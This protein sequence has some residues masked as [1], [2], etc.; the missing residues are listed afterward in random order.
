MIEILN[1]QRTVSVDCAALHAFAEQALVRCQ[2]LPARHLDQLKQ[3]SVVLVSDREISRLHRQFLGC[4]RATDVITFDHGE[5]VISAQTAREQAKKFGTSV[6]H[7]LQLY[8]VHGLL[9]LCGY[10]DAKPAAAKQMARTQERIRLA[11]L[12]DAR[13]HLRRGR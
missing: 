2:R 6:E 13:T 12:D 9:H 11:A 10:E 5:I 3:I 4:N 7:E 1:R 8:V